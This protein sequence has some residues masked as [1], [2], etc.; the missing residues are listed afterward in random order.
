MRQNQNIKQSQK[1]Q[2]L[3]IKGEREAVI[4][5]DRQIEV[6]L[7]IQKE[8]YRFQESDMYI[9]TEIRRQKDTDDREIKMT[10]R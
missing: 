4:D 7:E 2:K 3:D 5:A 6:Q 9:Y 1:R 8:I 10:E